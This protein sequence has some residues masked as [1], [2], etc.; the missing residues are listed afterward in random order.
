MLKGIKR[1]FYK[2]SLH[3]SL[4]LADCLLKIHLEESENI[5][6][7]LSFGLLEE[8]HRAPYTDYLALYQRLY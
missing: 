1:D 6:F 7:S 3:V 8:I 2:H 5:L 4:I